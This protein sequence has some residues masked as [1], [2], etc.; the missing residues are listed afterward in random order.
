MKQDQAPLEREPTD[1]ELIAAFQKGDEKAFEKLVKRYE[2]RLFNMV[3]GMLRNHHETEDVFQEILIK[4]YRKLPGFRGESG[5][6]TWLYR[7]GVNATWDYLRKRK[8]RPTFSLEAAIE[9]KRLSPK[10]L[11]ARGDAPGKASAIQDE[12]E[13]LRRALETLPAK[14]RVILQLK[15]EEG[16]SYEEM[17]QVLRCSIGTVESRLFRAR[18]KLKKKL[19]PYFKEGESR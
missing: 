19:E 3:F 6:F 8:R 1:G 5:F 17:A 12:M 18:E 10:K 11:V 14:H 9:E 13:L 4:V 16:L 15:E 2:S 7:V